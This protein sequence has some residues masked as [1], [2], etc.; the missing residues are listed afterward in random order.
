MRRRDSVES[1][2]GSRSVED[3]RLRVH[4]GRRGRSRCPG[5]RGRC[6][7][8][9][10]RCPG[11]RRWRGGVCAGS[12]STRRHERCASGCACSR[13]R[14]SSRW[15]SRSGGCS[16]ACWCSRSGRRPSTG[17][18]C[19]CSTGCTWRRRGGC[20]GS[21]CFTHG[22]RWRQGSAHRSG[23]DRRPRSGSA[24]PAWSCGV[25]V[26]TSHP[27]AIPGGVFLR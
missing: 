17:R 12:R 25:R 20:S 7:G 4:A 21:G 13:G 8:S 22:R 2:R 18:S 9:R 10:R 14:S 16:S 11:S 6:S 19:R 26:T 5:S 15:C 24:H 27:R 23:V 3:W 1:G